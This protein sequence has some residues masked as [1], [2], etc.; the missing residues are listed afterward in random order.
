V[1]RG[2]EAIKSFPEIV[3]RILRM[4]ELPWIWIDVYAGTT[5]RLDTPMAVANLYKDVLSRFEPWL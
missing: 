5:M 4:P 2:F 1:L 3:E